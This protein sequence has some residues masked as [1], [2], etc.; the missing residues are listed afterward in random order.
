MI[1]GRIREGSIALAAKKYSA[2]FKDA[3]VQEVIR[4]S[5]PITTVARENGLV[6]QTL[7]N[8][9]GDYR[10]RHPMPDPELNESER[11]KTSQIEAAGNR[12][13]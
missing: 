3:L 6:E 13:P 4:D 5:K 8:W 12:E 10:K 1:S 7:R 9:V 2:E 11:A